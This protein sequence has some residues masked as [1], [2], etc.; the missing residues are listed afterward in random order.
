[1]ENGQTVAVKRNVK[2]PTY[3]LVEVLISN[4][5]KKK[6]WQNCLNLPKIVEKGQKDAQMAKGAK[7]TNHCQ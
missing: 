2:I 3:I 4:W 1:M 6:H 5:I 7:N